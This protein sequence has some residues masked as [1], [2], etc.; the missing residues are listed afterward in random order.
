MSIKV[1]IVSDSTGDTADKVVTAALRQ[2]DEQGI[3][4]EI[5]SR[6]RTDDEIES[7]IDRAVDANAL[8]VH[9]MVDAQKR[10]LLQ[11]RCSEVD[12]DELDLIGPLMGKLASHLG[13]EAKAEPGG[14][15]SVN[16]EYF[17]RIEAVEFAVKNDDGQH[18]R[19]L[20]KADIVLVGISRTSKT[21]LSTYLA[22]RGYKVANVPLVMGIEPPRELF[23]IDQEKIFALSIDAPA[24]FRIRQSRLQSLGMPADTAYGVQDHIIKEIEY[25]KQI[26]EANPH[27]PQ[28]DV[29]DRAI[30]ETA[31][32]LFSLRKKTSAT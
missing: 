21:P 1:F 2:F 25:A 7:I 18:P 16:A 20:R 24:L 9:T 29:T 22:Q 5:F 12:L 17:R 23:K 26:F 31:A 8:V 10:G 13:A 27:W 32:E 11:H 30:E 19:N 28:I 14:L 6:V 15:Y 4:T 3:I